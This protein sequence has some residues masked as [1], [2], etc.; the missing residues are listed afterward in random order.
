MN[1]AVVIITFIYMLNLS[2]RL[3]NPQIF[4]RAH[5]ENHKNY[6]PHPGVRALEGWS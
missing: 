1:T 4:H 6:A 3:L 2:P 5:I